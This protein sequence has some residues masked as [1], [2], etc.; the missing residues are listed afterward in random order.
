MAT[1]AVPPVTVKNINGFEIHLVDVGRGDTLGVTFY[2][3]VGTLHEHGRMMGRAHLLEHILHTGTLRYPGYHSFDKLLQP[4]GINTNAYTGFDRTFYY[5][6]GHQSQAETIIRVHLSMLG[7]LEFNPDVFLKERGVVVNEIAVE[8]MKND[9][10]LLMQMPFMTLLPPS[11]PWHHPPLAIARRS[12]AWVWRMSKN[13][14]T[15]IIRP[16]S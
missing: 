8:G 16:S 2:V 1:S 9:S 13:S 15:R 12:K 3:P 4:V 5:A 10:R 11:H 6:S 14:T 7:G